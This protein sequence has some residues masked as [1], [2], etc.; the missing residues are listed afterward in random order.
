MVSTARNRSLSEVLSEI[1]AGIAECGNIVLARI[2][3]NEMGDICES[4]R[5]LSLIHI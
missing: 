3:L 1:V 5:F 4:C 2:W